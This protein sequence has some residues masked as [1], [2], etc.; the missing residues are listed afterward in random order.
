MDLKKG[1]YRSVT[2]IDFKKAF[3]T[4]DRQILTQKVGVYGADGK[5]LSWLK[6][7]LYN[8]KQCCKVNGHISSMESI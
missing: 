7:H 2:F 1:Q 8:R 4:V 6:S 5:E 3:D